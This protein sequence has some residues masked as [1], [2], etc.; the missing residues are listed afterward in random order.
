MSNVKKD[1]GFSVMD[2]VDAYAKDNDVSASDI[3]K[4]K[5]EPKHEEKVEEPVKETPKKAAPG[6]WR[7]DT[8]VM[9][10]MDELKSSAVSYAKED[11]ILKDEEIKNGADEELKQN[12][13]DNF[14]DMDLKT[15]NIEEAKL[16]HGIAKLQ[17]PPSEIQVRFLIAAGEHDHDKA[18]KL[19]DVLLDE[20]E[21]TYP[22]MI[23]EYTKERQEY[24]KQRSQQPT[25]QEDINEDTK[26]APIR[27]EESIE[28]IDDP[29]QPE[30]PKMQPIHPSFTTGED[31]KVVINKQDVDKL[32]WTEDEI[33][34]IRNSRTLEL[35]IVEGSD[36]SFG[37][38]E[39]VPENAVDAIL[40]EYHRKSNDISSPLPASKYRATFSGLTYPEVIDLSS[41]NQI[42]NIDGEKLKW[43]IV[44]EHMKNVSIGPWQEYA[45]YIDPTT[46]RE[47]RC[48][49][50]DVLPAG[51]KKEDVHVVTKYEDFLRH[52]SYLDLEFCLWKILCAT[53]M[54]K[55]VI[56][57]DCHS[58]IGGGKKCNATYD[59]IYS[60]SD[61][62]DVK[63]MD[64]G[65]L[66]EMSEAA[67]ANSVEEAIAIYNNGPVSSNSYVELHSSGFRVIYG[68]I[69][70]YEYLESYYP[71]IRQ[72]DNDDNITPE[73]VSRSLNINLLTT[74]KAVLIPNNKGGF[75]RIRG[76]NNLMKVLNSLDEIDFETLTKINSMM[77]DPYRISFS[78]RGIV[79]KKCKNRSSIP[80]DSMTRL[81]FIVAR[82][83]ANVDITLKRL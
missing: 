59:W 11:V 76:L 12:V 52:T 27:Q 55:E 39:D 4:K 35:N 29:V 60:P 78:I 28:G 62:L 63:D 77:R 18:Q 13:Q 31:V 75:T 9:D 33:K 46:H 53:A 61:L 71:A 38:I 21:K 56:S 40:A 37:S 10:G 23:L 41:A 14:K 72:L 22:E 65:V 2:M 42:N 50:D 7:P 68:H 3:F 70:A 79:C 26:I 24:M 34:K 67:G 66:E 45:L 58:D 44:F 49:L 80:I 48:N 81:L 64:P 8:S 32:E 20:V 51:V 16:R 43:T 15:R 17:I 74:V 82:S 5:E 69:S 36:L 57:I 30:M 54:D 25:A 1:S 83:L 73:A 47:V 6:E 19:L